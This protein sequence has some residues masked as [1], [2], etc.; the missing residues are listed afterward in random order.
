MKNYWIE[1][2]KKN[3][4]GNW[5]I[6]VKNKHT[7]KQKQKSF[8]SD[9]YSKKDIQRMIKEMESKDFTRNQDDMEY[10]PFNY[11]SDKPTFLLGEAI[12]EYLKDYKKRVAE[13]TFR[14]NESVLGKFANHFGRNNLL[15]EMT[16]EDV[17]EWI[18]QKCDTLGS[19]NTYR[20]PFNNLASY[21]N[22]KYNLKWD[23][24]LETFGTKREKRKYKNKTKEIV[25]ENDLWEIYEYGINTYKD[26]KPHQLEAV[27][28]FPI[29]FYTGLRKEEF[30]HIK[31][32]D[33]D[34]DG[35]FPSAKVGKNKMTKTYK[36][37]TIWIPE[38]CHDQLRKLMEG[39]GK[40]DYIIDHDLADTN[41]EIMRSA[42][43]QFSDVCHP[44]CFPERPRMP[45]YNLRHSCGC[46]MLE[47]GLSVMFVKQQ[48]G[49]SSLDQVLEYA[50]LT[51][52]GFESEVN[53]FKQK[54][55]KNQ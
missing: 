6:R 43:Y 23:F 1:D 22:K 27:Y 33:I 32:K 40:N 17:A 31:I 14:T 48:F 52:V 36:S 35:D 11:I 5:V 51:N 25:S 37:R 2:P 46:W 12:D 20:Y 49:H 55:S 18:E 42:Y 19:K 4:S 39:K 15:K 44:A 34:L 16:A 47:N 41:G 50:R 54:L 3:S 13:N 30:P 21:V 24:H 10:D 8:D 38:Q 26:K 29:Y 9:K 7:K 28:S 53:R 45:M